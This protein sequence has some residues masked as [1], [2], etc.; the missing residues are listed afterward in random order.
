MHLLFQSANSC[1]RPSAACAVHC[2]PLHSALEAEAVPACTSPV[3]SPVSFQLPA[4]QYIAEKLDGQRVVL[5]LQVSLCPAISVMSTQTSA[6]PEKKNISMRHKALY[7]WRDLLLSTFREENF[8][9]FG[10]VSFLLFCSILN[11]HLEKKHAYPKVWKRIPDNFI[12]TTK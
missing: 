1:T 3:L 12:A 9:W 7:N 11:S 2:S 5:G 4:A 10:I 8:F 6:R